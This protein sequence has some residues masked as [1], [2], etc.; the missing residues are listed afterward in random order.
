MFSSVR[1]AHSVVFYILLSGPLLS[2]CP[3]SVGYCTVMSFFDIRHLITLFFDIRH[4][5]T[6]FFDI[7][8]L[9][10]LLDISTLT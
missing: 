7:R 6:L 3:F 9:I 4:L 8:H 10:T 2:F 1:V 5:I